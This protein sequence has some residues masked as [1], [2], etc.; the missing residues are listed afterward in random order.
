MSSKFLFITFFLLVLC[1]TIFAQRTIKATVTDQNGV[2]WN[3]IKAYLYLEESDSKNLVDSTEITEGKL[4]FKDVVLTSTSEVFRFN[5][6][7]NYPNPFNQTTNFVYFSNGIDPVTITIYDITGR[8]VDRVENGI[9]IKGRHSISWLGNSLNNGVYM[10]EFRNG[11]NTKSIKIVKNKNAGNYGAY[12]ALKSAKSIVSEA[13]NAWIEIRGEEAHPFTLGFDA[14]PEDEINLG[15]LIVS[16]IEDGDTLANLTTLFNLHKGAAE[17]YSDTLLASA[18][19]LRALNALGQWL[20]HQPEVKEAYYV[21]LDLVEIHLTNGLSTDILLTPVDANE[22]HLLRGGEAGSTGLKKFS[23]NEETEA[24][25]NP[26]VLVLIPFF[27]EFYFD[28]WGK[29]SQ[30]VGGNPNA[31]Q[32]SDV[33]LITGTNVT[34]QELKLMDSAGLIILNTHGTPDGFMLQM[35]DDGFNLADTARFTKNDIRYFILS[36][37]DVPLD[38]LANGELRISVQYNRDVISKS[39][40]GIHSRLTVT[41]EYVRNMDIDL[42]GTVL[43]ANH[44]YSGWVGNGETENNMSQAWL[45]KG[46]STYYGYAYENGFSAAVDNE[47]CKRMEDSLIVNLVQKVDA[48]GEAHLKPDG[49]VQFELLTK[50]IKRGKVK[51]MVMLTDMSNSESPFVEKKTPLYFVQYFQDNY[52]Y[53]ECT[54]TLVDTRDGQKY[55][56]VSIGNQVWMAE[57]LNWAGAGVCYDNL[58]ANCDKYGRLYTIDEATGRV[59]SSAN[60]SSVQGVC[61]SGWHIP[62]QAEWQE[63]IDFAGGDSIAEYKL[64]STTDWPVPNLFTNEL[65]FNMLPSGTG[66][67]DSHFQNMGNHTAIWTSTIADDRYYM[68]FDTFQGLHFAFYAMKDRPSRKLPCRCVKDK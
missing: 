36:K 51:K 25:D 37:N 19:T 67:G 49:S 12:T 50:L 40:V 35:N 33:T 32:P 60:P 4:E 29:E 45:S 15:N 34:L 62:S 16:R 63:L 9:S 55:C 14:T 7:S 52:K 31:P 56:T 46:L 8:M 10:A 43:F 42:S 38:K 17:V 1:Q 20:V 64:K 21:G 13:P 54:D 27:K 65:G 59:G 47:F 11:Q 53:K 3:Q 2:P 24:I 30:F 48:T 22:Q 58:K 6:F 26:G 5:D 66:I 68:A 57:N 41:E 23:D 39:I 61:P 44:C 18:D 28:H